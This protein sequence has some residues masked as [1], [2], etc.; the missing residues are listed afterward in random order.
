[1]QNHRV[2]KGLLSAAPS[3]FQCSSAEPV[4]TAIILETKVLKSIEC[5][6]LVPLVT[7]QSLSE[8]DGSQVYCLQ[9]IKFERKT[10]IDQG[11]FVDILL[12]LGG[13]ALKMVLL[14]LFQRW[15][16]HMTEAESKTPKNRARTICSCGLN[17]TQ[18]MWC[19]S[20]R[21]R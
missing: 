9:K 13:G 6:Q 20:E 15:P 12:L 8:T 11:D 21:Q 17:E 5:L 14:K 4:E 7:L 18:L 3:C 10:F 19:L 2:K 1:M 16:D